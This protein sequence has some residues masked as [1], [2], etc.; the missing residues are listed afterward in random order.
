AG[1]PTRAGGAG[2]A[3]APTHR[4]VPRAR[5]LAR[6]R[7]RQGPLPRLGPPGGL[8]GGRRRPC[9][10]PGSDRARAVQR[11]GLRRGRDVAAVRSRDVRRGDRLALPRAL[12]VTARLAR[13]G[14]KGAEAGWTARGRGTEQ[15]E[16]AGAERGSGL[17]PLRRAAAPVPLLAEE[18][19]LRPGRGWPPFG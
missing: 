11:A 8:D 14:R 19:L 4:A 18:P 12:G 2:L 13:R 16:L 7:L 3:S 17:V 15:R 5:A 10:R 6:R 9:S 1:R